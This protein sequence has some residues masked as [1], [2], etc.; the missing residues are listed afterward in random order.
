MQSLWDPIRRPNAANDG[1]SRGV[2]Q[3]MYV[4]RAIGRSFPGFSA[5]F[6]AVVVAGVLTAGPAAAGGSTWEFPDPE[7]APGETVFAWVQVAW[8]HN[9]SLGTP[10]D[11]PWL[12]WIQPLDAQQAANPRPDGLGGA[13]FVGEIM[14]SDEPYD[15][16][17]IRFGPH[18]ATISFVLPDVPSGEYELVHCNDPCTKSLG[19]VTWGSFRVV[20]PGDGGATTTAALVTTTTTV[21]AVVTT[22]NPSHTLPTASGGS[23]IS[24]AASAGGPRAAKEWIGG[25]LVVLVAAS[26]VAAS[27]RRAR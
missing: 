26:L 20:R 1:A 24:V 23:D 21:A 7:V 25:V 11:G 14:V 8:D 16:G 5:V 13:I 12:A 27:R 9:P 18:H 17:G 15:A 19:D 6:S 3:D 10:A 2:E 22:T 4:A